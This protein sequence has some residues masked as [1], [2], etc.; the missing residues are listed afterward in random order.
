MVRAFETTI[1]D[2][3]YERLALADGRPWELW[4]GALVEKPGMSFEHN[5][6]Q[7]ELAYQL[8][9]Q[10]DRTQYRVRINS[11]RLRRPRSYFIPD[12]LVVPVDPDRV[13]ATTQGPLETYQG[14]AVLV[15]E[16]WSPS[17][18]R[19]DVNAK[20]PEYMTRGDLEIWRMHPFERKVNV[21]RRQPDGS[22]AEIVFLGGIVELAALPGIVVDLDALFAD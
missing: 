13:R 4:D 10:L 11:A 21:W 5:D 17:T 7:L 6:A 16:C 9:S 22:Y 18:G 15:V 20:L 1:D 3:T 2:E 8:R 12:V 19:Y 14:P